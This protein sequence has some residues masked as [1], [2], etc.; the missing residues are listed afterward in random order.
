[1][2]FCKLAK[3]SL[4]GQRLKRPDVDPLPQNARAREP[5]KKGPRLVTP[6]EALALPFLL[7]FTDTNRNKFNNNLDSLKHTSL[8]RVNKTSTLSLRPTRRTSRSALLPGYPYRTNIILH[9]AIMSTKL[10]FHSLYDTHTRHNY[11]HEGR[12]MQ[13]RQGHESRT[14]GNFD[15]QL[16]RFANRCRL[17]PMT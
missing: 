5:R 4:I 11:V 17:Y 3:W 16:H 13:P 10:P 6:H 15:H 12:D 9:D 8:F 1:V 2:G 7:L 14:Q